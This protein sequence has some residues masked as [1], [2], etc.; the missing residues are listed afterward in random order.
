MTGDGTRAPAI[1]AVQTR[2]L[3]T[4]A[5]ALPSE[6]REAFVRRAGD[7]ALQDASR[8]FALAWFPMAEHMRLCSALFDVVG[9]DRFLMM[10]R[11]TFQA[12]IETP[13]LRG[14]FSMLRRMS[15]DS[16]AAL[17]RNAPRIY[18]Y[19]TR[20]AG[21][22]RHLAR[23]PGDGVV[24]LHDWPS[25]EFAYEVWVTGTQGCILGALRGAGLGD[26]VE[27]TVVDHNE[28]AGFAAYQVRW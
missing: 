3:V 23:G 18:S 15:D 28:R 11:D 25:R 16:G 24:E 17:L 22:L 26:S 20:D 14:F 1:R 21:K 7:E 4:L 27:V 9:R 12:T 2:T 6:L 5:A 13:M 19:V 8:R 10:F